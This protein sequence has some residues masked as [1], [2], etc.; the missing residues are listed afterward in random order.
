VKPAHILL[1][2]Q[3]FVLPNEPGGTRHYEF[4]S[5][6]TQAGQR[7]TVLASDRSYLSGGKQKDAERLPRGMKVLRV[8][9]ASGH[10]NSFVG[11]LLAFLS[12]SL[13]SVL[14]GLFVPDIDLVWG[15]S[16][17]IF[18]AVSAWLIAAVRNVPFVLEVRDLWPEFPIALGII[19][20]PIVIWWARRVERFLYARADHIIVNSPAYRIY[21]R[22]QCSVSP[23]RVTLVP[24]GVD[25]QMFASG[26]AA[27]VRAQY[28]LD[29]KFVVV[30]GGAMGVANNLEVL[31]NAASA[32]RSRTDIH[33]LL[34]G[35]GRERGRLESLKSELQLFNV[36]FT[37]PQPKERMR[38]FLAAADATVAILQNIAAFTT[39]YPNKVF[40]YL[41]AGK[42]VVLAI[43][44]VIR[45]VVE[46]AGAG[47]FADP[48]DPMAIA[49]AITA[50]A[51]DRARATRMGVSGREYVRRNFDREQQAEQLRK[52]FDSLIYVDV[53]KAHK[54]A[55]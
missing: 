50:L 14:R 2:H 53:E 41:A 4:A 26:D 36:T 43:D 44:G 15:T 49:G 9:T 34:V 29:S 33:F 16:P 28:E 22:E 55:V 21:L 8:F 3:S 6:W 48:S 13:G 46:N 12:F 52:I 11:R 42:P 20:N 51:D 54:A 27:S 10:S 5:R 31:L 23:E 19:R 38:D 24:N 1:V 32:L 35:D 47:I 37:G 45:E 40:D 17:P 39:T 25:P 7:C 18:Q 30:Y